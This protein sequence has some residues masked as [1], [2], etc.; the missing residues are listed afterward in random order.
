MTLVEAKA[1]IRISEADT[2]HDDAL[3]LLIEAATERVE[4][5]L[6]RQLVTATYV[7]EQFLWSEDCHQGEIK[8]A[9]K[10]V[11]S[12]DLIQYY[13]TD[14]VLSTLSTDDYIFDAGRGSVFPAPGV[15]WPSVQEDNPT[16]I[17]ITFKA[18]YGVTAATVPRVFKQAILLCIGKWFYDPAS[19]SSALHSQEIAYDRIIHLLQ[20]SV[21]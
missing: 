5:D 21:Y 11:S 8:L 17:A 10:G 2:T 19:E 18:G 6:D 4:H 16:A 14:G 15:T 3:A 13:D 7:Q 12:V 20:R 9:K 1:H